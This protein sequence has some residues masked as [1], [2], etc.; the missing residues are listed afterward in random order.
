MKLYTIRVLKISVADALYR[1]SG[2]EV[3]TLDVSSLQPLL[4][5]QIVSSYS[6]D[7]DIQLLIA[8]LV[9]DVALPSVS[10]FSFDG[11]LLRRKGRLVV[12]NYSALRREIVALC[13]DSSWGGHSGVHATY[14][15]LKSLFYWK[16]QTKD[17][18]KYVKECSVCQQVKSE[19]VATP[20][21]LSPLP[22]PNRVFT[23]IS[24]DFVVGLP[25]SQ[26][27]EVIFVVVDRLT[28]YAHFMALG[29]PYSAS[30][31]A[32]VFLDSVYKLH[33]CP[34]SIVSDRD[35]VF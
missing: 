26:G 9:K 19:T 5:N 7:M 16:V 6:A 8:Q 12:G 10:R 2:A 21:L 18:R 1:V 33:G 13:H 20:G 28:K 29:H 11:Q 25:R 34:V 31:V 23:D 17:V 32:E 30:Q 15:R 14:Q 22:A 27:K 4:L 3:F 35:S 24:M